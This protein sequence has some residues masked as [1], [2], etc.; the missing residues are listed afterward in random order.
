[1]NYSPNLL[2]SSIKDVVFGENVTVIE[3]V[4]LYECMIGNESF[5]GPFVEIQKGVTIG[6]RT[7]IQSHSFIC[8]LVSIGNDCFMS[9]REI[10]GQEFKDPFCYFAITKRIG[11]FSYLTIE[12]PLGGRQSF[13]RISAH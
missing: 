4:N 2:K 6:E 7:K 9:R 11:P 8:E 3:P 10:C 12:P 1:M 5:V 13:I